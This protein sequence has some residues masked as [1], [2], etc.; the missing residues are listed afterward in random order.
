[1]LQARL[2]CPA[3]TADVLQDIWLKLAG[4]EDAKAG[5]G[6]SIRNAPAFV[7][8]VARNAATDHVRKERRR[9]EIDAEVQ[10]LLWAGIDEASP[11]RI[12]MGRQALAAIRRTLEALPPQSREIFVMNRFDG[13]TH[14]T[15]AAELGVSEQTVYYHIKRALDALARCRDALPDGS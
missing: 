1:M 7:R 9:A 12:L 11:E 5:D 10:H 14:K 15:I 13:K 6:A 3:A 4:Q 2:R 8:S